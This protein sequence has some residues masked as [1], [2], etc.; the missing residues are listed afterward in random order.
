MNKGRTNLFG[1]GPDGKQLKDQR[2][3]DNIKADTVIEYRQNKELWDWAENRLK[4]LNKSV[5]DFAEQSQIINAEQRQQFERDTYIPFFRLVEDELTG[6]IETVFPGAKGKAAPGKIHR[7]EGSAKNIG[8]PLNNLINS[9]SFIMRAGLTNLAR[10]KSLTSAKNMGL[11]TSTP[12]AKGPRTIG[13]RIKGEEKY[14]NVSDRIVYDSLIEMDSMTDG[15][16]SG[17]MNKLFKLFIRGPK[18]L[19]TFGVTT[20]PAFRVANFIRDTIHTAFMER[21]Y[22]NIFKSMQSF[23]ESYRKTPEFIEFMSMGGAFTGSYHQRDTLRPTFKDIRKERKRIAREAKSSWNPVKWWSIYERIGEASENANRFRLYKLKKKRGSTAF[24]AAYDAKDLLDFHRSGQNQLLQFFTQSV[25]FLNARIQGLYKL[26]RAATNKQ[27]AV[28]FWIAASALTMASLMLHMHNDDD[29][30]YQKLTDS[31]R[32]L[33]WHFFDVPGVGHLR[34]PTP[35]EVGSFFG[36]LP[37]ALYETMK[38]DR[39]PKEL[40]QFSG[41]IIQDILRVDVPQWIK[42]FQAQ[43][44]NQNLFTKAPIVPLHL[45]RVE[46]KYQVKPRTTKAAK[47]IGA[48]MEKAGMP[49]KFQSPARIDAFIT[50]VAAFVGYATLETTD[51]LLDMIGTYPDDPAVPTP[52][53][54]ETYTAMMLGYGRF[55]RGEE[56]PRFTKQQRA[57]YDY[58]REYDKILSTY[59]LLKKNRMKGE[60]REYRKEHKAEI[61]MAKQ[62]QAQGRRIQNINARINLIIVDQNLSSKQKA[63]KIDEQLDKRQKVFEK[64]VGKVRTKME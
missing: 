41:Q 37:A 63:V 62:L 59:N 23:V 3:I 12:D 33:Y 32:I 47:L 9:Y 19:L 43:A 17:T 30:R 53:K 39:T 42:P 26:G 11:L 21:T 52:R 7:L 29:E 16:F 8:D 51:Q 24:E 38:G 5:L 28:N 48:G 4:E 54:G 13:I 1:K 20:N 57:Y 27:N 64:L 18:K 44:Q 31:D 35:F 56:P 34:I 46:P 58:K 2:E 50:D 49:E 6:D 15:L 10:V 25:P 60:R 36:A 14:F 45:E 61:K 55:I 40:K 22:G